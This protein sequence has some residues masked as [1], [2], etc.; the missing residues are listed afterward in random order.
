MDPAPSYARDDALLVEPLLARGWEAEFVAWR[1]PKINWN[2]FRAVLIRSPW[3][4]QQDA[5]NFL[6]TLG[7]IEGS[8]ARLVNSAR[9]ARWNHNKQYL[10]EL[11]DHGVPIVPTMFLEDTKSE[12]LHAIFEDL[13]S[14][15]IVTKPA[16]GAGAEDTHRLRRNSDLDRMA[17][18]YEGR[19][20]LAQPFVES[21]VE[22]GE[23]SLQYFAG[24]YSHCVL[25]RPK[26][27]DF[28]TQP[29]FGGSLVA[30]QADG[31]LIAAADKAMAA[32]PS[33]PL[34]ARID[35]VRLADG[36]LAVMEVELIEPSLFLGF[37]PYAA[38][39]FAAAFVE[40]V[41]GD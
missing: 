29:E 30:V 25:K 20:I 1:D 17:R 11:R 26:S 23:Y 10:A 24:E 16:I 2:R 41:D 8:R 33:A 6:R 14:A 32:L 19:R 21:I 34:Y 27:T 13:D 5:E 9:L 22:E 12:Q 40:W 36:K 31:D 18:L 3:D 37:D 4:Y 28:R 7:K 35:L 39:R 38:D 15:V